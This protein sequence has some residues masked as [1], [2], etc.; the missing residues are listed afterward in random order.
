[1]PHIPD[2]EYFHKISTPASAIVSSAVRVVSGDTPR[3]RF[4]MSLTPY[5][6]DLAS[7]AVALA[8]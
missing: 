5:P 6:R 4:R 2:P 3:H 1:M 8:Q 7:M